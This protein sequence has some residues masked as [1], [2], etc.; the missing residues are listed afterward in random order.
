MNGAFSDVSRSIP[1][2]RDIRWVNRIIL[3]LGAAWSLGNLLWQA[4]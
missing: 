3:V 4:Q 1:A 2:G